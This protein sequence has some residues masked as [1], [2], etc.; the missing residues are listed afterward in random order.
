M[1]LPLEPFLS[2]IESS[3]SVLLSF[4]EHNSHSLKRNRLGNA[5]WARSDLGYAEVLAWFASPKIG[6]LILDGYGLK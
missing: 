4:H 6:Q 2:Q 3:P 1:G 5:F